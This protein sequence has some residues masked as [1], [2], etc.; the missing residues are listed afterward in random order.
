M[1]CAGICKICTI[2]NSD[3][4]LNLPYPK[5]MDLKILSTYLK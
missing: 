2:Q 3:A 4:I 1:D 5:L